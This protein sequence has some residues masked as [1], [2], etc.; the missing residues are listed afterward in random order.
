MFGMA[1]L[2]TPRYFRV[3]YG[4]GAKYDLTIEE[5]VVYG[6][7]TDMA[8]KKL[9]AW[10]GLKKLA[11]EARTSTRTV[12]RAIT[13]LVDKG[14]IGKVVRKNGRSNMYHILALPSFL[15]DKSGE[16]PGKV[17]PQLAPKDEYEQDSLSSIGGRTVAL[18]EDGLSSIEHKQTEHEQNQP[19]G[20][21][22]GRLGLCG[23]ASAPGGLASTIVA[24]IE[25]EDIK[26][27]LAAVMKIPN[28]SEIM[29][30]ACYVLFGNIEKKE[31]RSRT[32]RVLL[33]AERAMDVYKEMIRI[34]ERFDGDDPKDELAMIMDEVRKD[35]TVGDRARV[36]LYR[37]KKF[38]G[39]I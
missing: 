38:V 10:P 2:A 6:L 12:Q 37:L 8:G 17:Q 4:F 27:R 26:R 34:Q 35:P 30:R 31:R 13:R 18:V 19:T 33:E 24:D 29:P 21:E 32:L 28:G 25:E 5:H 7:L 14:L 15:N 39:E 16:N 1:R 20:E 23:E 22:V 11:I 9:A 36:T 3:F